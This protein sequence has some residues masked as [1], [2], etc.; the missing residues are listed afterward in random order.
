MTFEQDIN[1][2]NTED[3]YELITYFRDQLSAMRR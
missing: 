3:K 2:L 1:T